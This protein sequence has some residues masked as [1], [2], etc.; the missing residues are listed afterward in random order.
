MARKKTPHLTEAELRLMNII[1]KIGPATVGQVVD[2]LPENPPVA[3]STVLTLMRIL[4]NKG[5]LRH[6][7][8]GRAFV[9]S[10][11]VG[12]KEASSKAIRH[13]L[14]R[15]FGG[16]AGQ[17][18]LKLIDEREIDADELKRIKKRINESERQ[19]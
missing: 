13:L 15:F 4:E 14:T 16:S 7:K 18:V 17:L 2:A 10:P 9:Y 5:Y 12:S 8:E 19:P 1:W 6:T 11:I 3:Y